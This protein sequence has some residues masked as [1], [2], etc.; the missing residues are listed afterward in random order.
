MS[1]GKIYIHL[2]PVPSP[3]AWR[4]QCRA[5]CASQPQSLHEAMRS[6]CRCVWSSFEKQNLPGALCSA[7]WKHCYPLL[8]LPHFWL[9]AGGPAVWGLLL[10]LEKGCTTVT[11]PPSLVCKQMPLTT[12]DHLA[13]SMAS[14]A[15]GS[16]NWKWRK[17]DQVRP[18]TQMCHHSWVSQVHEGIWW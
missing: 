12:T 6:Y 4:G 1:G 11:D 14:Q 13:T 3:P 17:G 9:Y 18:E 7:P 5:A 15:R 10:G 8:E 2:A 16:Y